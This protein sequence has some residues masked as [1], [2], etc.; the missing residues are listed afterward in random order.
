ML[1]TKHNTVSFDTSHF[2]QEN[3]KPLC[4]FKNTNDYNIFPVEPQGSSGELMAF[5]T[6]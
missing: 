3:C 2:V 5:T 4:L 6:Y 1:R